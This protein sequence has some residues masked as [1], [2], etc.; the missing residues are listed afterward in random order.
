MDVA[1]QVQKPL[2]GSRQQDIWAATHR[3]YDL[4][5]WYWALAVPHHGRWIRTAYIQPVVGVLIAILGVVIGI[6]GWF[7]LPIIAAPAMA[8]IGAV[9][10]VLCYPIS[11]YYSFE[12]P[13]RFDP[14]L[15][16][17]VAR[18][19]GRLS[20]AAFIPQYKARTHSTNKIIHRLNGRVRL[21]LRVEK[22][23]LAQ[24]ERTSSAPVCGI[25]VVGPRNTNKTGALWDA[26]AHELKGW[27]FVKWPHHMDHP[28]TLAGR[29]GH[30]TVLWI[31]D[32]HDFA[33]PGEAA[34]L[35]QFI[36]KLRDTGQQF[37]VLSSC[38]DSHNKQ[39]SGDDKHD[40]QD[41]EEAKRYFS[42]LIA[43]LQ[44]V[45]AS[46][47][48]PPTHQ[49]ED[50]KKAY[51]NDLSEVQRGILRTIDWL[52]SM[53]IST[54]PEIVLD[55]LN[56]YFLNAEATANGNQTW[57]AAIQ[58]LSSHP[59]RFAR[60]D[61]R[62]EAQT[63]LS[64][65]RYGFRRWLRYNFFSNFF[66]KKAR[67]KKLTT[68]P[69]KFV[70]PLNVRYLDLEAFDKA[71]VP[72]ARKKITSI[73]EQQPEAV[74]EILAGYEVAAETLILL[75]DAYLNHL[76]E[77]IDNASEL[78]SAC[79][80]AALRVPNKGTSPERCPGA[81]AAALVGKG[82]AELR[83]G[84]TKNADDEFSKVTERPTPR[85]DARPIPSLLIARAWHGRGDV[86]A[87]KIPSNEA[88]EQLRDAAYYYEQA[89]QLLAPSD[90]LCSEAKR[91]RANIFFEIAQAAFQEYEQAPFDMPVQPLQAAHKA[92]ED[93][94]RAYLQTV[95][96]A[97]WAEAQRRQGELCWMTATYLLPADLQLH[98]R[99]ANGG[100]AVVNPLASVPEALRMA[101]M[102]RDHFIAARNVFAPSYLP[103]S[104][105]QTQVGLVRALL[106]I[107]R[108]VAQTE[109]RQARTL[110]STC[111]NTTVTTMQMVTAL[112]ESPLDR[113]DRQLLCAQAEIG[114]GDLGEGDALG[115]YQY[116][117]SLLRSANSLLGAY[118]RLP[119]NPDSERVTA[120]TT[121]LKALHE[122]V[123][124]TS[125]DP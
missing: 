88:T 59:A 24:S 102:A 20:K 12:Y 1:P 120:Q 2:A 51:Q 86:I 29:L 122:R 50:I 42:P 19:V 93:A 82:T 106:I 114:I 104:W 71:R 54:F 31:D 23:R 48:L 67:Q 11:L 91:D 58:G 80:G 103:T 124:Q 61:Q 75:G 73:L 39:D 63:R 18:R 40:E 68:H 17:Y 45:P 123:V 87:A 90:P 89:T 76:G 111:L 38:R 10:A 117:K 8:G 107:A 98:R 65:E 79:Y 56:K 16:E 92:Y 7:S 46:E 53:R 14:G 21:A 119:E 105:A 66:D 30:R 62:T 78:A 83:L 101:K 15:E 25:L 125:P 96:P 41:F 64:G 26:M 27:T 32:L 22:L 34:A 74:I 100:A 85:D 5:L 60:V 97:V 6:T 4:L 110:Y 113:V 35:I 99:P 36:Q 84:N 112:A 109:R 43:D 49:I 95:A 70:E 13:G 33:R 47:Q 9:I 57:D 77:T 28:A 116:A 118:A 81:W 52:Q 72:N 55:V 94:D 37:L 3:R 115:R 44:L 108:I 121:T 69:H